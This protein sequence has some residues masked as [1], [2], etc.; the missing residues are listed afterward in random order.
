MRELQKCLAI[1]KNFQIFIVLL[2]LHYIRWKMIILIQIIIL[3]III[4][5]IILMEIQ[6]MVI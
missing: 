2:L 6:I 1:F 4:I 5:I 3:I